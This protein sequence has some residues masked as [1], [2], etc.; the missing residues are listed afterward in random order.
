MP[1]LFT[2]K[3]ILPTALA[4]SISRLDVVAFIRQVP[5]HQQPQHATTR[6]LVSSAIDTEDH[7]DATTAAPDALRRRLFG[8]VTTRIPKLALPLPFI[9]AIVAA[10]KSKNLLEA[11]PIFFR[12]LRNEQTQN[13][14]LPIAHKPFSDLRFCEDCIV[15]QQ[16]AQNTTI[17]FLLEL[18]PSTCELDPNDRAGQCQWI[19]GNAEQLKEWKLSHGAVYFRGWALFTDADGVNQA[20][21][22]LDLTPCRDPKEIRGPAPL[23]NGSST[24]YE[25]LNN[26]ADAVT[27]LGLHFEGIPG[28][29]PTSALFS[30]FQPAES[31]GEFLLCD[32]R[33]VFRDL[34]TT[35]LGSLESK[36]LRATFAT[37]P[38]W[39]A[40]SPFGS[41]A[42]S[43]QREVLAL[44]TDFT[45]PTDDFF[46]GVFPED[47]QKESLKL[48]THSAIPVLLHPETRKPVWFSGM[49]AGHRGNFLKQ[50]PHLAGGSNTDGGDGKYASEVFDVRY[51]DGTEIS[52][53]DLDNVRKAC[54]LNT[55]EL[56]MQVG[57]AVFVDNFAVL[58]G[59]KPFVGTRRHTVVWFLD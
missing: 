25:T 15:A 29:M 23:L 41:F 21:K 19:Q 59:R 11:M 47:S 57:D 8:D 7:S 17:Q 14:A 3:L 9:S 45:R 56:P 28:I 40:N 43:L 35:T 22:A 4:L 42:T 53:A 36:R 6:L 44:A 5:L 10:L 54:E 50:N 31:G 1:L 32:G 37:I 13:E 30:C 46:L 34:D 51:G 33:Q 18:S 48:T 39:I 38:D 55:K 2:Y 26:D 49:D 20:C 24:I 58:H 27:H 16:Q 12:E 52:Q